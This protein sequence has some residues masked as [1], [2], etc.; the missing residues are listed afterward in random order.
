MTDLASDLTQLFAFAYELRKADTKDE[1]SLK[2]LQ[3]NIET[4]LIT[5]IIMSNTWD[6]KTQKMTVSQESE[7]KI[8]MPI[9]GQDFTLVYLKQNTS[10]ET[11]VPFILNNSNAIPDNM[12]SDIKFTLC[13]N[14]INMGR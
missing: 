9:D 14:G 7:Y 6:N 2:L 3:G 8:S 13:A 5:D 11:S 10:A 1:F 12:T 4:Q